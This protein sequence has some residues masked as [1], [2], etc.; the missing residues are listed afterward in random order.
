MQR[1]MPMW[2][3]ADSVCPSR[4][5]RLLAV[6]GFP[7]V[8][9][10]FA[11]ARVIEFVWEPFTGVLLTGCHR[12]SFLLQVPQ[13]CYDA[14]FN[15]PAGYRGQYASSAQEGEA[16]NRL[17][18]TTLEPKLLSAAAAKGNVAQTDVCASIRAPQAKLWIYE[19]EVEAQL[20]ADSPEIL[21]DPWAE[22]SETGVG[23]LAPSGTQLEVKG[24][25]LDRE[26]RERLNPAK[27]NRSKEIH[28]T[29]Y[30]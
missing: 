26:G 19:Q 1:I 18:L 9:D 20:G 16:A 11:A 29:G 22:N 12:A 6:V 8:V 10:G 28:E 5:Q 4:A 13:E 17:L 3:Y 21:Y 15:S 25:W 24:G 2:R 14:F 30:S 27:V 7:N 23:L